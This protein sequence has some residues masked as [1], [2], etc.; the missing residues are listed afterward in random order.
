MKTTIR[1]M[2]WSSALLL[3]GCG[4]FSGDPD[5]NPG[6]AA[7]AA[8]HAGNAGSAGVGGSGADGGSAGSGASAGSGGTGVD[9]ESGVITA[10]NTRM[11]RMT[12]TEYNYTIRDLLGDSSNPASAFDVD[13][14]H[15]KFANNSVVSVTNLQVEQYQKAA[16][17]VSRTAKANMA[18]LLMCDPAAVGED[19]CAR[20]FIEEFGKRAYRKPVDDAEV[21][22]F[23]ALYKGAVMANGE[24]EPFAARLALVIEAMLQS[25][26]FLYRPVFGQAVAEQPNVVQLSAYEMASRLSYLMWSTMPDA[27]LFQAAESGSLATVEGVRAEAQR[28]MEDDK[29]ISTIESFHNQW[30]LLDSIG[31]VVKDADVYPDFTDT[32]REAMLRE[33]KEFLVDVV[34]EGDGRLESLFTA[35]HTFV[36]AELAKVYGVPFTGTGDEWVRVELPASERAG[37]LTQPGILATLA[38]SRYSSPVLRGVLLR[39]N[40]LCHELPPPPPGVADTPPEVGPDAT[41]RER[42]EIHMSDVTC[43]RC[44]EFIDGLGYGFE[45]FDGMGKFRTTENGKP[46]NASGQITGTEEIDGPYNGHLELI[47]ILSTSNE[48]RYCVEDLWMEYGLGHPIGKEDEC[49]RQSIFDAFKASDFNVRELISAVVVSNAFRF[50]QVSQ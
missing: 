8:G 32:L 3:F 4:L 16:V 34:I 11:R 18:Q 5:S 49:S 39:E 24:T 22:E 40:V 1:V 20:T 37:I 45:G 14:K 15:G 41:T 31:S 36:N 29:F 43:K 48:V 17:E 7:G 30:L 6:G 19:V 47:D 42:Y 9:C 23:F 46:I 26:V 35:G 13:E 25:P 12:R 28:M 27:A 38:Q 33:T 21:E 50:S 10:G 44:H 2:Q